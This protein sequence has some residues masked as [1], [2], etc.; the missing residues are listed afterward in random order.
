MTSIPPKVAM[1]MFTYTIYIH[2]CNIRAVL[3]VSPLHRAVCVL[4][5][6]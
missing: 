6:P 2:V 3:A 4:Y 1:T 5:I